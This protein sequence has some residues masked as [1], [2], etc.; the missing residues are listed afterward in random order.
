MKFSS[1]LFD[2]DGTLAN[3]LPLTIYG[4]QK[5][6]EKY[7]HRSLDKEGIVAMFGPT[8]DGMIKENFR[9]QEN[10]PAA[11]ELYYQIYET[12][13]ARFV[14]ENT[15]ILDL[16]HFLQDK[17][18]P[19][20]VITGKSRRAYILSEKALGFEGLFQSV[21]T[22]DD[23]AHPKPD[24][25]GI[26]RTLQKFQAVKEESIY[27]GDSNTDIL[28]GKAAGVHT[29]GVHWLPVSQSASFSVK[30]DFYWEK[31]DEFIALLKSRS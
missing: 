3:T 7:D 25:E 23:V 20:G 18:I 6:F 29:A 22:G 19:A 12:E 10:V 9:Y 27:I 28:A 16:L 5:V 26:L 21:I 4:M 31:V 1:V 13:H 17:Q 15:E 14:K 8:E 2:F 11:I 30:P 24:T